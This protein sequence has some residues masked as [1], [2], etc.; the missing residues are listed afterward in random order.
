MYVSRRLNLAA[1]A[2][3]ALTLASPL[4]AFVWEGARALALGGD[5]FAVVHIRH[6][7]AELLILIGLLG[8]A[9]AAALHEWRLIGTESAIAVAQ[10]NFT[11]AV[12]HELRTPLTTIRM[13]ADMLRQGLVSDAAQRQTFLDGICHECD[14][15][16][17]LIDD[18]LAYAEL[19]ED[20]R[21]YRFEAVEAGVLVDEA[22]AAVQ[23]PLASAGMTIERVV[24]Q[25]LPVEVDRKAITHALINLLGNAVKYA[26]EGKRITVSATQDHDQVL[27]TVQDF[28]PGIAVDEQSRVFQPFYR[29]GSELTRTHPGSG[30][31]LALVRDY[32]VAHA[33]SVDLASQPGEG[34][35][36]TIRL[37]RR[38][39]A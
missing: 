22:I 4:I 23:G 28:G 11:S 27:F 32:V 1:W 10:S 14:R 31:G 26:P 25:A 2:A 36:F 16:G 5:P 20:R 18:L 39:S 29:V 3:I 6:N 12:T 7:G 15:L 34:A 21:A 33:G 30:L 13:Y 37:P 24:P 19:R 9:L 8:L 38:R 35:R 17:G